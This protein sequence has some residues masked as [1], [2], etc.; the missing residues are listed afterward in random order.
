ML[1]AGNYSI[2]LAN[3]VFKLFLLDWNL[4]SRARNAGGEP[5]ASMNLELLQDSVT[6]SKSM[7]MENPHPDL[8]VYPSTTEKFLGDFECRGLRLDN[9][10]ALDKKMEEDPA[11]AATVLQAP[12]SSGKPSYG[13]NLCSL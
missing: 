3:A 13:F 4:K 1:P 5:I 7:G 11:L 10:R 6:L 2:E 12:P 9:A 8:S